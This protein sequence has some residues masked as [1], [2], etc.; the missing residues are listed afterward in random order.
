MLHNY[1]IA[2]LKMQGNGDKQMELATGL[3]TAVS[4]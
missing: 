1:K 3:Q 4:E 2:R